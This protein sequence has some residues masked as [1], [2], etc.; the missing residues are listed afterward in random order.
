MSTQPVYKYF[1]VVAACW[2]LTPATARAED[3]SLDILVYNVFARPYVVSHDGQVE[4]IERIGPAIRRLERK[5]GLEID[6]VAVAE[7]FRPDDVHTLARHL[8]GWSHTRVET[9]VSGNVAGGVVIFSRWP[10][11]TSGR[12]PYGTEC[13][14]SDCL[15]DKGVVYAAVRPTAGALRD[16]K[17]HVFATHLQAWD[18]NAAVREGQLRIIH[19][20]VQRQRIPADEPVFVV[21]D[22]NIDYWTDRRKPPHQQELRRATSI[23]GA[24]YPSIDPAR[25]YTSDPSRNLLVG[26]DGAAS[27]C[28]AA[29]QRAWGR[30][31]DYDPPKCRLPDPRAFGSY[32]VYHPPDRPPAGGRFCPCCPAEWLDYLLV[33]KNHRNPTGLSVEAIEL[34]EPR[35]FRVPWS[36]KLEPDPAP[37]CGDLIELRDLSDHDPVLGRFRFSGP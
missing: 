15:G 1:C 32:Y 18:V 21:G 35:P 3:G 26:R 34:R 5:R 33:L 14:G 2:L 25:K 29:Y 9:T 20:F 4:R 17:L 37:A 12:E 23:L 11:V 36:G 24:V 31:D 28:E 8:G 30:R 10:I 16:Q 19:D 6:L 7:L 27:G 13:A 22:L